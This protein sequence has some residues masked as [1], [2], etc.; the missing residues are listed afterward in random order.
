MK[1]GMGTVVRAG[2]CFL[3]VVQ[4]EEKGALPVETVHLDTLT[5]PYNL[6]PNPGP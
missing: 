4:Q 2:G 1:V 3:R 5:K 6:N